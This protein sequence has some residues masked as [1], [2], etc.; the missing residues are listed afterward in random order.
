MLI[1]RQYFNSIYHKSLRLCLGVLLMVVF[2][3]SRASEVPTLSFINNIW[4]LDIPYLELQ[5][6]FI[7]TLAY[8]VVLKSKD[9]EA[10]EFVVDFDTVQ[11]IAV[12]S[13]E[14]NKAVILTIDENG[15]IVTIP[16]IEIKIPLGG[17]KVN[18]MVLHSENGDVFVA[19]VKEDIPNPDP[20]PPENSSETAIYY[21]E[22][23][24][25]E[26]LDFGKVKIGET[27]KQ[28]IACANIGNAKL[29]VDAFHIKGTHS[30]DFSILPPSS[31]SIPH[32]ETSKQ[33]MTVQCKPSAKGT[34]TAT[35]TLQT[36]DP[37]N[38]FPSY[39]LSCVG[40]AECLPVDFDPQGRS[41]DIIPSLGFGY[42][43]QRDLYKPQSCLNG[44]VA[45][46]GSGTAQLDFTL[47]SSYE[48]LKKELN[49][50]FDLNIGAMFFKL[51][52]HN[53]FAVK[54]QET[55]LSKSMVLKSEIL[56]HQ[57]F[58]H[59]S[60][61]NEFGEKMLDDGE[62]C[63]ISA[64]GDSF[65]Y[66][67]DIGGKLFVAMKFDFSSEEHKK[68]FFASLGA[69]YK[70]VDIKTTV[71]KLDQSTIQ[72]GSISLSAHQIGGDVTKLANVFGT[73]SEIIRC[74]LNDLS[75]C[76]TAME[77]AINYARN[78][79]ANSV[80]SHTQLLSFKPMTY[81]NMGIPLTA[82][83]VP[84]DII[85]ARSE[86]VGLYEQQY[87]DWM[88]AE[89]WLN[90]SFASQFKQAEKSYLRQI[91]TTIQGNLEMIRNAGLWCFSDLSRC[92]D[93]KQN[94]LDKLTKYNETWLYAIQTILQPAK[95]IREFKEDK[96]FELAGYKS[97]GLKKRCL[98]LGG[99][100][101]LPA[102][103][104][105]DK[106]GDHLKGY[107]EERHIMRN[108]G[109]GYGVIHS[110]SKNKDGQL[111]LTAKIQVCTKSRYRGNAHYKGTHTIY[112]ECQD[113][114]KE[115]QVL[116]VPSMP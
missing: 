18:S 84:M 36:N 7:N 9:K 40:N 20:I 90:G 17:K 25:N 32:G 108:P 51:K 56:S 73:N 16:Y 104:K 116:V 15:W 87:S 58:N 96:S 110:T 80:K 14:D 42:D 68:K 67:A 37:N 64:C 10:N 85:K 76:I 74:S 1:N 22:P 52:T 100:T 31:L 57:Q 5:M 11:E 63:F 49:F 4:V 46:I 26:T 109:S 61:L 48:Q 19:E 98:W 34:R 62:R 38:Q 50:S 103:C 23:K 60:G 101:C 91:K 78:E 70:M 99:T 39:P 8:R 81:S 71:E 66:Q 75:F 82:E 59:Q 93:K 106:S 115:K 102:N 54:H 79:F 21:S 12:I 72:S 94:A 114:E 35:L 88:L 27:V 45:Q 2:S 53:N 113:V 47:I 86:L 92:L 41:D 69:S 111:C 112:G 55:K 3:V 24:P 105:L 77:N 107:K 89:G 43:K 29:K 13:S 44:N 65:V 83:D 30:N 97:E 28:T 95:V 33:E 6:P